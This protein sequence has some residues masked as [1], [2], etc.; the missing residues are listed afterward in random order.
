MT[1]DDLLASV[2]PD[3]KI[4]D[5]LSFDQA[6]D[7][8]QVNTLIPV[9]YSVGLLQAVLKGLQNHY[10]LADDH[11]TLVSAR[12]QLGVASAAPQDGFAYTPSVPV[13]KFLVCSVLKDFAKGLRS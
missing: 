4:P 13:D 12:I 1:L 9:N 11:P 6:V 10:H 5:D 7:Y 8:L 2:V 3:P